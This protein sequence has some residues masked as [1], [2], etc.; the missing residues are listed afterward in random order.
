MA[1]RDRGRGVGAGRWGEKRRR[2]VR[3]GG[4][5]AAATALMGGGTAGG[6]SRSMR[7]VRCGRGW[8]DDRRGAWPGLGPW[9]LEV[10]LGL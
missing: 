7:A 2:R 5:A 8:V 6:R 3:N 4:E 10:W 9:F 1:N